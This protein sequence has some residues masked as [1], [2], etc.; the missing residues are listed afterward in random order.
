LRTLRG[1]SFQSQIVL[2]RLQIAFLEGVGLF[3]DADPIEIRFGFREQDDQEF[4]LRGGGSY[5]C[6]RS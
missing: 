4:W 5:A 1:S 3:F 6:G 2:Q